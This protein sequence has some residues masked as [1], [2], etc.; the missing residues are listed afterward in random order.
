MVALA[1]WTLFLTGRL[2]VPMR[3]DD[4]DSST[5][6]GGIDS[7]VTTSNVNLSATRDRLPSF[8]CPNEFK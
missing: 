8:E 3:T 4:S 7:T 6:F 1:A 2:I 5:F